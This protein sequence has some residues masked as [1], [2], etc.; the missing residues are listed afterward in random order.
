[1][2]WLAGFGP[3]FGPL[4][5]GSP[6]ALA[7]SFAGDCSELSVASFPLRNPSSQ[8]GA[9]RHIS[10]MRRPRYRP[11]TAIA[12]AAI[13]GSTSGDISIRAMAK[14]DTITNCTTSASTRVLKAIW[15]ASAGPS[16]SHCRHQRSTTSAVTTTGK[17]STD[18]SASRY[19]CAAAS[20]KTTIEINTPRK[21]T[22]VIRSL[23]RLGATI[24]PMPTDA[25]STRGPRIGPI[26]KK[27][28]A[29]S[30][31]VNSPNAFSPIKLRASTT[32]NAPNGSTISKLDCERPQTA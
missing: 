25:P 12:K 23:S 30:I 8:I 31:G 14:C 13:V 10:V 22:R 21:P 18:S 1:M 17:A 16:F 5:I 29:I 26:C 20:T 19:C 9:K 11:S 4:E 27:A 28:R 24:M 7:R 3:D 6:C 15:A 32:R 2:N